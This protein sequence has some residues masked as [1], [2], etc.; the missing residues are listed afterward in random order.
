[1]PLFEVSTPLGFIV[2]TTADYWERLVIK[3]PDLADRLEEVKATLSQ[4]EQIRQSRRDSAVLL[5]YRRAL[6]HWV[7][8]VAKRA[9]D[10]AFLVTAYQTDA[11]KEGEQIWPR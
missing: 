10:T 2:H 8:A 1:M 11:I 7:V 6:R 3:H 4:P 5:F 9:D